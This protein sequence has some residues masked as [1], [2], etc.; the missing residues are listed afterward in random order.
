MY[1][2]FIHF[3]VDGPLE[4]FLDLAVVS[5]PARSRDACTFCVFWSCWVLVAARSLSL[6]AVRGL[7]FTEVCGLLTAVVLLWWG[8]DARAPAP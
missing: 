5:S 4:C 1:H 2:I 6:A 8:L 3:S 7:L